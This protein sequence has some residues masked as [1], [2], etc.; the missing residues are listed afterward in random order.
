MPAPSRP[1]TLAQHGLPPRGNHCDGCGKPLTA[2]EVTWFRER[3]YHGD[4]P[5]RIYHGAACY[6]AAIERERGA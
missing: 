3:V 2:D 1:P 5:T 4:R 6:L